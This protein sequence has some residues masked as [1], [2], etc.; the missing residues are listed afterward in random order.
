MTSWHDDKAAKFTRFSL[1]IPTWV[2]FVGLTIGNAI[3]LGW[4]HFATGCTFG[5]GVAAFV[6]TRGPSMTDIEATY[7]RWYLMCRNTLEDI[8]EGEHHDEA[9]EYAAEMLKFI[10]P[11]TSPKEEWEL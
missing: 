11:R 10:G 8:A 7:R 3:F 4:D 6:L 1:A 2:W 5:M 9:P